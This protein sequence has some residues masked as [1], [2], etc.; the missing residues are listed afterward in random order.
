MNTDLSPAQKRLNAIRRRAELASPVW[1][2]MGD[3]RLHMIAEDD[4]GL[5]D[6]LTFALCANVD[7]QEFIAHAPEDLRWL[8]PRYVD[9]ARRLHEARLELARLTQQSSHGP[10]DPKKTRRKQTAAQAC[11]MMCGDPNFLRFLAVC[12]DVDISDRER[13]AS[14]VRSLLKVDSRA[15]LDTDDGARMRW[16][17]LCDRFRAWVK[18]QE[19]R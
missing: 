8:L 18:A 9:V 19:R 6:V 10:S 12:E 14:R 11:G 15:K 17:D 2:M 13:V 4:N 5:V 3:G 7:D 1:S 16:F